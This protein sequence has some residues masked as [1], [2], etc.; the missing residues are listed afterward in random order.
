[1]LKHKCASG[2]LATTAFAFVQGADATGLP[3]V[4]NAHTGK[5][6]A[7][8]TSLN[9]ALAGGSTDLSLRLRYENV[10]DDI[11]AGSP[12]AG[13]DDADMLSLRAT[14]GYTTERF[15]GFY[16]RL[17]FEANTRLDDDNALNI[18]DDLTF[19]P[20]PVASRVAA[21]HSIIPDNP[22]QQVNEAYI[23]WRSPYGCKHSPEPC[24]GSTT[25]K[26]GR[27]EVIYDNHRWVGNIVW[28]Q[29]HMSYDALRIDNTLIPNLSI[30]YVYLDKVIRTFGPESAFNVWDM[31]NSH[32]INLA[33]KTPLGKLVGYGY[34]LDFEDNGRTPF[35]EGQGTLGTPGIANYDSNTWGVRFVGQHPVG[36]AFSLLYQLEWANQEPVHDAG[37]TLSDNDYYDIEFGGSFKLAGMPTVVRIGREVLGGNGVNALQTPLATVHAFNGWADKFAGAPGGTDTPP[38]GLQDTSIA[39]TIKGIAAKAIGPS[40]FVF[41]YHEYKADTTVAGVR[42]YGTEWGALFA[43]PIAKQWLLLA[44]YAKFNDGGDGFSYDTDK[45]WLMA[46]YQFQ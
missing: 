43:K 24:N 33:Y 44:K 28:R 2:L 1:M 20:G 8:T 21:G 11:P 9:K 31:H 41:Q 12:I 40:K 38:G 35:I 19:P 13:T 26:I 36:N 5:Q 16:S 39:V 25:I 42:D 27:Q 14:L 30:S 34:L 46:Q 23:G 6:L 3:D 32:L 37:P 29:N 18:D 10:H 15:Y 22:F 7:N 45:Y 17:E 4:D